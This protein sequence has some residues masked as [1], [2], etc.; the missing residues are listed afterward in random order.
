MTFHEQ[1]LIPLTKRR[2]QSSLKG[3]D[4]DC[5]MWWLQAESFVFYRNHTAYKWKVV[6]L[7]WIGRPFKMENWKLSASVWLIHVEK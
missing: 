1:E 6:C 7:F 4:F 5:L 2:S 3:L